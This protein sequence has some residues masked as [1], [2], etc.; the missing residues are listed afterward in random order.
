MRT[1]AIA[2]LLA[3]LP[4]PG[5][6]ADLPAPWRRCDPPDA[7]GAQWP[8]LRVD[9]GNGGAAWATWLQPDPEQR[10]TLR[11]RLLRFQGAAWSAAEDLRTGRDFFA[12]WADFAM[13]ATARNGDRLVHWLRR[14]ARGSYDVVVHRGPAD[15]PLQEMGTPYGAAGAGGEHGFVAALPE[16]EDGVRL[17]WLDGRNY[18]QHR[19]MELRTAVASATGF[20]GET[21]LDPDV[22][23]CCQTG[24][25]LVGGEPLVVYRGHAEG[26]VRDV[27]AV[28]RT[29]ATWS[30]PSLVAADGWVM[31]GCPVNGPAVCAEGPQAA[32]AWFTAA[33]GKARVRL[34]FTADGGATFAAPIEVDDQ[35]PVGRV[36]VAPGADGVVLAWLAA[37]DDGAVLAVQQWS[38]AGT[39][40][41][42]WRLARLS[43]G[44][45]AGFPR[46]ARV[47]EHVLVLWT[48]SAAG[49]RGALAPVAALAEAR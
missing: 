9:A 46:I 30:R 7:S 3:A 16:G 42:C 8:G 47:G 13:P 5:Q 4:L 32:V 11:L 35:R 12:N 27:M 34:A 49:V 10:R 1:T 48:E 28:R 26:E 17:F 40:G 2:A 33:A 31:P 23:T 22:C 43:A 25:A 6:D 14:G 24:A 18:E 20:A 39:G 38:A 15:G 41:R 29:G 19:R 45:E 36:D 44:R 21:V 37:D